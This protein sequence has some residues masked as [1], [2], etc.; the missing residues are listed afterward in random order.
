MEND[1][2]KKGSLISVEMM[3]LQVAEPT[4]QHLVTDKV[5]MFS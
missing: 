3:S 4:W 1:A 5:D 2:I